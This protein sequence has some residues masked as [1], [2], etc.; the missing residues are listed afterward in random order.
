MRAAPGPGPLLQPGNQAGAGRSP[1]C[2]EVRERRA[3]YGRRGLRSLTISEISKG[4]AGLGWILFVLFLGKLVL[5]I[6][7]VSFI[8]NKFV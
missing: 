6:R 4:D 8:S 3:L 1:G 7:T 2:G 5:R